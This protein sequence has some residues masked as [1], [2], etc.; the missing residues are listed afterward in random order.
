MA[1]FEIAF[2]KTLKWE[3]PIGPKGFVNDPV[4]P[5]GATQSGIIFLLWKK[6]A[7]KVGMQPTV[8]A[9]RN[10]TEEQAKLIYKDFFWD[11]MWG[12]KIHNQSVANLLFDTMVNLDELKLVR[13]SVASTAIQMIQKHAATTVDGL[14]GPHTLNAINTVNQAVMFEGFKDARII[15]YEDLA[16]RKPQME[17]FLK[18]WLARVNDFHFEQQ[19]V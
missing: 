1:N 12:D 17:K 14:M 10:M 11:R 15:Y 6:Y 3:G 13:G 4:D 19:T 8:E 7:Y 9:L 18:G 16:K 5:G 2:P